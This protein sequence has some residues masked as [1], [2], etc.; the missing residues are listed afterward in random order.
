MDGIL[1]FILPVDVGES[2]LVE[3]FVVDAVEEDLEVVW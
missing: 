3:F 2:D 1:E